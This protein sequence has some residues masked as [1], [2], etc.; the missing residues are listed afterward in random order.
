MKIYVKLQRIRKISTITIEIKKCFFIIASKE[1]Y[2]DE[3]V[4]KRR[5]RDKYTTYNPTKI[6]RRS[7]I[8]VAATEWRSNGHGSIAHQPFTA[9]CKKIL[10]KITLS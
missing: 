5:K 2:K 4:E 3:R 10:C 7:E 9:H 8:H 1:R 6:A